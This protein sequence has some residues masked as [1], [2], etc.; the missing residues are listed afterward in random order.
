M[1]ARDLIAQLEKLAPDTEVLISRQ[2]YL[3]T[4]RSPSEDPR[5]ILIKKVEDDTWIDVSDLERDF[6]QIGVIL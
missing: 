6:D 3:G 4:L 1:K 5:R 2:D